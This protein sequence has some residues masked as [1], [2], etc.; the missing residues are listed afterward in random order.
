LGPLTVSIFAN[1]HPDDENWFGKDAFWGFERTWRLYSEKLVG[2]ILCNVSESF[3]R[4]VAA[5]SPNAILTFSQNTLPIVLY[6]AATLKTKVLGI[7]IGLKVT[8]STQ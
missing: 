5:H 7:R 1:V 6:L 2:M 4:H 8:Y 3:V